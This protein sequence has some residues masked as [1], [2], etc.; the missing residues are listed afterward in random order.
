MSAETGAS[1][2]RKHGGGIWT[3]AA[4]AVVLLAIGV[5]LWGG[6]APEE[7]KE[8]EETV[9]SIFR[10]TPAPAASAP[11]ETGTPWNLILVNLDHPIPEDWQ[12]DPV[13]LENGQI[14]DAR[15]YGPLMEMFEAA[16]G[17]NLDALPNVES[18]YRSAEKQQSLFDRKL[19]EFLREGCSG[20]EAKALTE[21][22]VSVPGTSEHQLGIAV[23]ISGEVYE[24][25]AWLRDNSW[26]YGFILRYPPD[27]TAIT[28][29]SGEEWHYRYVGIEAAEEM[30]E[31]GL[32][33]EEYLEQH[34]SN[35]DDPVSQSMRGKNYN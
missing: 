24:I 5:L 20:N 31:K 14:V 6:A 33:L 4:L 10:T 8:I 23:D 7:R 9:D 18:G 27:K 28:G 13:E 35:R 1:K 30:Y 32:C 16:R 17:V 19:S 15:I 21:T 34:I 3:A 11:A 26:K 12:V 29:V 22:W 25:Y 2:K